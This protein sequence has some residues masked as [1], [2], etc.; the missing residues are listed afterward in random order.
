MWV[1]TEMRP[2][3]SDEEPKLEARVSQLGTWIKLD[4]GAEADDNGDGPPSIT[5]ISAT[6]HPSLSFVSL[7]TR[8]W[9][10]AHDAR[11]L[12]KADIAL[13]LQRDSRPRGLTCLTFDHHDGTWII[14]VDGDFRFPACFFFPAGKQLFPVTASYEGQRVPVHSVNLG[15]ASSSY[16]DRCG[17]LPG[18]IRTKLWCVGYSTVRRSNGDTSFYFVDNSSIF[19]QKLEE[20][21]IVHTFSMT[22][23]DA[24]GWHSFPSVDLA[25]L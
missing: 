12:L 5:L 18:R 8:T 11:W 20:G 19:A 2:Q 13:I 15:G 4:A 22:R 23:R 25:L 7:K 1:A 21:Y 14:E 3:T 10:H 6:P 17:P 9:Q 16:S 24:M